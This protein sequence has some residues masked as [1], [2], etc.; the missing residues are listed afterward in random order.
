MKH[1]KQFEQQAELFTFT[2]DT[3]I[4]A[5]PD[6]KKKGWYYR[7]KPICNVTVKFQNKIC[8]VVQ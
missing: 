4:K 2:P 3:W 6:F 8:Q 5:I 7:P 1:S